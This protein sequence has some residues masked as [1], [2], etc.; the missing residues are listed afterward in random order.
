MQPVHIVS[1]TV[2]SKQ[3]CKLLAPL[4]HTNLLQTKLYYQ[5]VLCVHLV[6]TV[7]LDL[8]HLLVHAMPPSS[9]LSEQVPVMDTATCMYLE[10]KMLVYVRLVSLALLEQQHLL[11]AQSEHTNQTLARPLVFLVQEALSVMKSA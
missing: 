1:E 6:N 11:L 9:V 8:P 3:M 10:L 7:L 4:E 5:N 2:Q